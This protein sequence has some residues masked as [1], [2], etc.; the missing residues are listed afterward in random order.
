MALLVTTLVE[1][2]R[3]PHFHFSIPCPILITNFLKVQPTPLMV[4]SGLS[5]GAKDPVSLRKGF[6]Q[7]RDTQRCCYFTSTESLL[8]VRISRGK[9]TGALFGMRNPWEEKCL[10]L[11]TS[12]S[13]AYPISMWAKNIPFSFSERISLCSPGWFWAPNLPALVSEYRDCRHIFQAQQD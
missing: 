1:I 10:H 4:R 3:F 9:G 11:F 12:G 5:P 13:A 7:V 2:I 6:Y 8:R